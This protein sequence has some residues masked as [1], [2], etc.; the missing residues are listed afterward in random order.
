MDRKPRARGLGIPFEGEPGPWNAI[1]DVAGVEVGYTTLIEGEGPLEVGTG[2]VRTGVTVILPRGKQGREPVLCAYFAFNGMGEVA[3]ALAVGESG[4]LSGPIGITNTHSAGTVRD[5]LV[6]WS[7][8]EGVPGIWHL[9]VVGETFDGYLNDIDGMHVKTRHVF[10]A[11]DAAAGGP[12]REGNVGGG[13]GMIMHGFKGGTGT[14]SRVVRHGDREYRVGVLVQGNTGTR[15]E[16]RIAGAPVGRELLE[17]GVSAMERPSTKSIIIVVATDAPVDPHYLERIAKRPVLG[18][19]RLGNTGHDT[20]GDIF[21]AFSTASPSAPEHLQEPEYGM[22]KVPLIHRGVGASTDEE[23]A[24]PSLVISLLFQATVEAT[25]EAIVNAL[26]AAEDMRGRDD[27][28]VVA[29]PHDGLR[30]ALR[31]YNRL[32]DASRA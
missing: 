15:P 26:V 17:Y 5:A 18:M 32:D 7:I 27:R 19:G 4:K 11:I 23:R 29:I 20:S 21:I 25:E 6:A 24:A 10:D 9:P 13:T 1:T 28:L 30:E 12:I 31:K 3:G 22:P 8:R 14:A 16:L 2:P